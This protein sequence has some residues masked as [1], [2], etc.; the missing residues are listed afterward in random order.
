MTPLS[1]LHLHLFFAS[2]MSFSQ[3]AQG[4]RW[5]SALVNRIGKVYDLNQAETA[6]LL[7]RYTDDDG[8]K[9]VSRSYKE[10]RNRPAREREYKTEREMDG[11]WI[12]Q[13]E[14]KATTRKAQDIERATEICVDGWRGETWDG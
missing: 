4:G 5:F 13:R 9:C 3:S 12:D 8:D 11:W 10:T 2:I 1:N 14:Y 6:R 7:L